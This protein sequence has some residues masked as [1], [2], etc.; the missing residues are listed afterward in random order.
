MPFI[1]IKTFDERAFQFFSMHPTEDSPWYFIVDGLVLG[2][3][4][5]AF[6]VSSSFLL[7]ILLFYRQHYST[8]HLI[9]CNTQA[10]ILLLSFM[11]FYSMIVVLVGDLHGDEQFDRFCIWRSYF[12]YS[13]IAVIY[14]SFVIQ[15]YYG[16]M[17]VIHSATPRYSSFQVMA[18]IIVIQWILIHGIMLTLP[19]SNVIDYDSNSHICFIRLTRY[20]ALWLLTGFIYTPA[21]NIIT[22]VYIRLVF[23]LKKSRERALAANASNARRELQLIKRML[24]VLFIFSVSAVPY[25]IF[26]IIALFRADLL[27]LHH[28][29]II[30]LFNCIALALASITIFLQSDDVQKIVP[31]GRIRCKKHRI[32]PQLQTAIR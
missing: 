5:I 8:V 25:N 6:L 16:Y 26:A 10:A 31:I 2:T 27:W 23:Y 11:N 21:Y 1:T 24:L 20:A 28:Y 12:V 17:R 32:Q 7:I 29:R 9:A 13:G 15:S 22:Y 4:F 19:L 18:I 14:Y 3:C 30:M